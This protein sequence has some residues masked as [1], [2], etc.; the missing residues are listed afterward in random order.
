MYNWSDLKIKFENNAN[1]TIN[2]INSEY[3][4]LRS[5]RVNP[6]IFDNIFIDY[7]GENTKLNQLSQIQVLDARN[8][9]IKPYDQ[10]IIKIT[11][12]KLLTSNLGVNPIIDNNQIRITFP[13]I[14]EETRKNTVKK[15]KEILEQGKVQIRNV[16]KTIQD[17][18]K[19]DKTIPEDLI[20]KFE[21]ELNKITKIFNSKL[22]EIYSN[23]EKELLKI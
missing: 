4:K 2:W 11:I 3:S 5:G 16:R 10:S 12:N 19:N 6:N 21:D 17:L 23:K 15:A 20:Y 13:P 18:Y 8:V 22:E 1:N 7:Y 9:V 14:T